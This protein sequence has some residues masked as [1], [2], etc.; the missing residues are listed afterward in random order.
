MSFR[1]LR[2]GLNRAITHDPP[3]TL[4]AP[5]GYL[6]L[7][8]TFAFMGE[9]AFLYCNIGH[10]SGEIEIWRSGGWSKCNISAN[11]NLI[12]EVEGSSKGLY[13]ETRGRIVVV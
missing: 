7:S 10:G 6:D 9:R 8:S 11:I 3:L 4:R 1:I 2:S 5:G 12:K 13:R